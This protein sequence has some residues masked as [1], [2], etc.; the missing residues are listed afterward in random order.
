M[1]GKILIVEDFT[2]WRELL[3]ELLQREGHA[4]KAVTTLQEARDYLAIPRTWTWLSLT[5]G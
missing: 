2:D 1:R 4:V 5:S 3:R